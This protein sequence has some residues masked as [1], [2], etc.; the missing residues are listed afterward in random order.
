MRH[1]HAREC[2]VCTARLQGTR[3]TG[4]SCRK[5]QSYFSARFIA[6][7]RR[8]EFK[9]LLHSHF[10]P[11]ESYVHVKE[12]KMLIPVDDTIVRALEEAKLAAQEGRHHLEELLEVTNEALEPRR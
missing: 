9:S 10:A 1:E 6:H 11:K 12:E 3:F 2:P 5:C 4:Y 7:V 8:A